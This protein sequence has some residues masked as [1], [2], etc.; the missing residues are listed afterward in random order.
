MCGEFQFTR[1]LASEISHCNTVATDMSRG[2]RAAVRIR[3]CAAPVS[4]RPTRYD[5]ELVVK[6]LVVFEL[7]LEIGLVPKPDPI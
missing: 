2:V 7:A 1:Q 5:T 4:L 6:H 3:P